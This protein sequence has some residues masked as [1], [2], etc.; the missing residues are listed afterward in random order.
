MERGR[1][2]KEELDIKNGHFRDRSS[3]DSRIIRH[4]VAVRLIYG[5]TV[6]GW[7]FSMIA[8]WRGW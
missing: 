6:P 7:L 5:T 3:P 8:P 4:S 2:L 1:Q